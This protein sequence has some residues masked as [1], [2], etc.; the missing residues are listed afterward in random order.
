MSNQEVS[1]L[2]NRMLT[3]SVPVVARPAVPA[4]SFVSIVRPV[5]TTAKPSCKFDHV[6][7]NG[8]PGFSKDVIL[9]GSSTFRDR[10]PS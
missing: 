5:E 2:R 6:S 1:L 8:A 10:I 9:S 4:V 3:S 7:K